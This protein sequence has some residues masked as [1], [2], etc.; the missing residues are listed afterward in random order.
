METRRV[1]EIAVPVL[2]LAFVIVVA[3]GCI[4]FRDVFWDGFVW[5][6]YWGPIVSDAGG[7]S[8]G[9]TSSYNWIDTLSYGLILALSAYYIHKLFV[10]LKLR[11]GLGFFLAMSSILLIGPSARVLEDMELFNEPLQYIFISPL[12]YIFLGICT[13]VTILLFLRLEVL[14]S[15]ETEVLAFA[16]ELLERGK[17]DEAHRLLEKAGK[18]VP[19]S[20]EIEAFLDQ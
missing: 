1:F 14:F 7:D 2:I 19:D 5:K 18:I 17:K 4:I 13:L 12:I 10:H 15:F 16:K 3:L 9:I 20:N 6:Y 11:T 8:G